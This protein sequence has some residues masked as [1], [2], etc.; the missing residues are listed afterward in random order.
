MLAAFGLKSGG[1]LVAVQWAEL[2]SKTDRSHLNSDC[3]WPY[4]S[5]LVEL[6]DPT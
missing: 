6:T 2:D 4:F 5:R 3:D 1:S